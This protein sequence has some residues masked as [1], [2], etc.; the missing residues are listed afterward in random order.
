[1]NVAVI[2]GGI[3]G[4]SVAWRLVQRGADVTVHDPG[5]DDGAWR[6]AAG[7]LAPSGES[8]FGQDELDSLALDSARRWP[9][10]AAELAKESG[11]D[12]GYDDVGTL[13]IAL[14]ADD[15]AEASRQWTYQGLTPMRP[16]ALRELEPALSP[17]VRA[18]AHAVEDRQVDPRRVVAALRTALVTAGVTIAPGR[19][20][21]LSEVSAERVVV[22]AGYGT[23]ALTGLPI[24]PV[25]G[26]VLRLRGEPGLI[27]HVLNG[28]VDGK[29][30]YLVPRAD[31]EIVV[32]ATQEERGD[33]SVTAGAVLDLLW[34]ATALVPELAEC[35][36]TETTAGHRPGT[37][38]NAPVLGAL[39]QRTIVAAGHYRNG[40]L[41][42]PVTADLIAELVTTGRV[43]PRLLPFAPGRFGCA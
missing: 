40:V 22:A 3:I 1:V 30:V 31:G 27:R 20:T 7:M 33:L 41:L 2:G 16:T 21:A 32:G 12:L 29:H 19:V 24:R 10:F 35:E 8:E 42:A 18:G 6:V 13:S 11:H 26:Q 15:L 5:T 34:A 25:K 17:R 4:L 43:D 28:Y 9:D 39:D 37:P 36:L 14:T 23:A 38:D